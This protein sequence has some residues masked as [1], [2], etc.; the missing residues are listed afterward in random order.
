MRVRGF[1][2]LIDA[3]VQGLDT[4]FGKKV[5]G[6]ITAV[7]KTLVLIPEYEDIECVTDRFGLDARVLE[8][9]IRLLSAMQ[10]CDFIT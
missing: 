8:A 10:D 1:N 2:V 4:R 3:L 5:V 9:E 7:G 6:L